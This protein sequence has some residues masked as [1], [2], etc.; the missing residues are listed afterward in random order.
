GRV[1]LRPRPA[2][3]GAPAAPA[4]LSRLRVPPAEGSVKAPELYARFRGEVQKA[5]V[6]Q[7]EAIR[8]CALAVLTRGHVLLEGVPGTGKTLLAKCVARVLSL[9]YGRVQF[10]P[11]LMPADIVGTA[12]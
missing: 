6:G 2:G 10:T 9:K 11:D 5:I 3:G 4:G 8:L 1:E 12:V 7:D